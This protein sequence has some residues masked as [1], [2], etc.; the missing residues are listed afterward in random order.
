MVVDNLETLSVEERKKVK[1]F[2]ET[3]TPSEMQFILTSRN[4]EDYEVNYK[5]AGFDSENGKEFIKSYCE[6]NSFDLA[7]SDSDKDE[8]LT[9]AKGNTLV[10]ALSMRRLNKNLYTGPPVKTTREK[11]I[12]NIGV[13]C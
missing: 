1:A 13:L 2:V 3:Q 10:L 5:L 8:L 7:L 4:S 9:L 6:E 12:V 11:I